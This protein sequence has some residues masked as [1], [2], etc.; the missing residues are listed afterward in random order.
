MAVTVRTIYE[1]VCDAVN[2][3][4]TT[5]TDYTAG[6][7]AA[8]TYLTKALI[9][10]LTF[11]RILGSETTY[12]VQLRGDNFD[13]DGGTPE[14]YQLFASQKRRYEYWLSPSFSVESN[15]DYVINASGSLEVTSAVKDSRTSITVSAVPV[16]FALLMV[17]IFRYLA[18]HASREIAQ[19]MGSVSVTP[20]TV[21][22]ELMAQASF[23]ATEHYNGM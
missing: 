5:D 3:N 4:T 22:Q 18:N 21:R 20:A 7:A 23:W 9:N 8:Q 14:L 17:D 15:V 10:R 11:N 6:V 2:F 1:E 12:T 13:F 16:N 19:S